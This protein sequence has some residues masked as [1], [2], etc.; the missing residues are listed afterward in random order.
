MKTEFYS[1]HKRELEQIRDEVRAQLLDDVI[2]FWEKRVVDREC[3]GYYNCFDREGQLYDTTKQG[4][5]VGRNLY[6]FSALYNHMETRKEWLEIAQAGRNYMDTSF[7]AGDG[8]FN[9]EL[10]RDGKVIA[11][12]TSIFTDHFAVK[13]LYEY[14]RAASKTEDEKEMMFAKTLSDE[15]F[16]HVKEQDVIRGEG[17]AD[18]WQKHAVNFMNLIVALESRPLFG[19]AYEDIIRTCVHKSLYEFAN[20][21]YEAPFEN[22]RSDG[23][24]CLEGAGRIVDAGHTMESLWFCMRA[25]LEFHEPAWIERAGHVM[26]WVIARCYD[27]TY[28][29]FVQHVDVERSCPEKEFLS[30]DYHGIPVGWDDK[31]WWVQAEALFALLMSSILNENERHF[32]YFKKLYGYV[33]QYFRDRDYGEWYAV[34]HREGS[35]LCDKKGFALKG[36]YHIPRCLMQTVTL[37]DWYLTGDNMR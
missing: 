2:P 20:D 23:T 29:G 17:I 31:I 27:E 16:C 28:G 35:V 9:Q 32:T 26:D 6:T 12:T 24:P 25:G 37:L 8:R 1:Q 10:D 4:W 19:N 36:A 33:E 5:F 11:G 3:G 34:L 30:T 14:I 7:Y 15:L 22:I 18:G 13:G 21:K